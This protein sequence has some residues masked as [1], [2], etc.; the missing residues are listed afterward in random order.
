M[1]S[2][3]ADIKQMLPSIGA[4]IEFNGGMQVA[5]L[6]LEIGTVY[7][8]GTVKL[9]VSGDSVAPPAVDMKF[10]FGVE[11]MVGLPIVGS[12]SITYMLGVDMHLQAKDLRVG[13][14]IRWSGTAELIAGLV[15]ITIAIEAAGMIERTGDETLCRAQVTFSVD[16][17]IFLVI[18]FHESKSWSEDKQ[19]A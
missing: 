19:I 12:V 14:F 5:C 6:S 17:S 1:I 3:S 9:R 8:V 15:C 10:G 2:V 4:F 13:A 11:L 7:A 16:I 18:D